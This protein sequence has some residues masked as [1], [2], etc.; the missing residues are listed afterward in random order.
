MVVNALKGTINFKPLS[1]YLKFKPQLL[2]NVKVGLYILRLYFAFYKKN[3]HTE[4]RVHLWA[5]HCYNVWTI[6]TKI[7]E[8]SYGNG[9]NR[10]HFIFVKVKQSHYRPGQTLRVPEGWGFQI[11]WQSARECGKV[12]SPTHRPTLPTRK[13]SWFSFLSEAKPPPGPQCGW[14]DYVNKKFRWH[15]RESNPRPF[16]V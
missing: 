3:E 1:Q 15:H 14:K 12:V 7:H 16:D 13:Y 8:T 9:V 6:R 2:W 10:D 11:S 5:L 4:S